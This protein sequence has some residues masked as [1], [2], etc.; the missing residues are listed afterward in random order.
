MRFGFHATHF[1]PMFGGRAAIN[2]VIDAAASA[3]FDAIG[4]DQASTDHYYG[5]GHSLRDLADH[6]RSS[7][8]VC[9]DVVALPITAGLDPGD[10]AHRL[11]RLATGLAAP[12][13]ITAV[14][15]ALPW[16]RMVRMAGTAASVL[17]SYN[18]QLAIE[19]TPYSGLRTLRES[20]ELCA[21]IGWD[22][23][24]VVIDSLHFFRGRTRFDE[25]AHLDPENIKIVQWSDAPATPRWDPTT[26]SRHH[27]LLPGLGGLPLRELATALTELGWDGVVSAEVL[28][29]QL[30]GDPPEDVAA[31]VY[32][33][34]TSAASGWVNEQPG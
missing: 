6:V 34:L 16:R 5:S 28:S 8:L 32:S 7:G 19:F 17:E 26:E 22:R 20:V 2:A 27:R 33:A 11:G 10:E 30:R 1:S 15:E 9:S 14:P 12:Y 4:V 24:G 21:A 29:A 31:R 23:C 18:C 25:L 3:G 13:C